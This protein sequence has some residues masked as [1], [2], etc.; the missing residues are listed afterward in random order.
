MKIYINRLF[1]ALIPLVV[2]SAVNAAEHESSH[3]HEPLAVNNELTFGAVLDVAIARYPS[4]T[5]YDAR[6]VEAGAWTARGRSWIAGQ[7]AL[8]LRYQSDRWQDENGL[9]EIEAGVELPL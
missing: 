3:Q 7:P 4:I 6:K 2:I 8:S 9:E 5:E 1:I